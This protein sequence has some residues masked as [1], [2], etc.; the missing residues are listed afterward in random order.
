M[1]F[2]HIRKNR[3]YINADSDKRES[4]IRK[5]VEKLLEAIKQIQAEL[6]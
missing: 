5:I 3:V 1:E 2:I 6:H 4:E